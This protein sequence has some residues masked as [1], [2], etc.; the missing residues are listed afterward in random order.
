LKIAPLLAAQ[1][2]GKQ[3]EQTLKRKKKIGEDNKSESSIRN[4]N[5]N[6]KKCK[7]DIPMTFYDILEGKTFNKH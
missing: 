2:D 7:V 6:K 5:Q 3:V 1:R 4:N